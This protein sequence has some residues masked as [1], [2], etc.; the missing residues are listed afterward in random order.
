MNESVSGDDSAAYDGPIVDAHVHFWDPSELRCPW[1]ADQ[2]ALDRPFGPAEYGAAADWGMADRIVF[3]EANCRRSD[4]VREAA[5]IARLASAES[6]IAGIV[7]FADLADP[8]TLPASL[9]A[10]QRVEAVRGLRHNIQGEP[11]GFCVSHAF[12][13]GVREAGR[14]GLTFDLCA[15]HD[16]LGEVVTLARR[17]PDTRLVLDH[18]GKPAITG[19]VREPWRTRIAELAACGNVACKL[20]GLLTEVGPDW[21]DAD[22]VPYAEHVVACFGDGRVMVGSDWPVLTLAG[23]L[24]DWHGFTRRFTAD[25]SAASRRRFHHDNAAGFYG[26]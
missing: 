6:R 9:D 23:T 11:P 2:P 18:C 1:L 4:N 26:L 13:D 15:T 16:Q 19:A 7:A 25:W 21:T 24:A 22:L 14:R 8:A 17:C 20:S 12:V 10:L 3:I 5:R